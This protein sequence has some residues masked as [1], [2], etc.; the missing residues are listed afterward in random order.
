MHKIA[1][2]ASGGG[3]NFQAIHD[4]FH[5]N[6]AATVAL[7]ITDNPDAG[8]IERAGQSKTPFHV[9]SPRAFDNTASYS[10]FLASKLHGIDLIVLAGYMKLIP[11]EL[12]AQFKYRIVNIH[13]ALIPA[14]CGKGYYGER[15]HQAVIESGVKVSGV[16]VHFVDEIFD[17]GPIIAQEAVPVYFEDTPQTLANRIQ[18]VEHRLYPKIIHMILQ[19]RVRIIERRVR[20]DTTLEAEASQKGLHPLS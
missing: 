3:T 7:L 6:G 11:G 18:H 19:G 9:V 13:P 15:V 5:G 17:H 1:V 10:S 14:F 20:I 16:T 8:V 12:I 2:F 4:F